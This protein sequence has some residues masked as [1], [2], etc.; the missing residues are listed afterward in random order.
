MAKQ[1][2]QTVTFN[3][4][5][6]IPDVEVV[7]GQVHWGE[8]WIV[9]QNPQT[10]LRPVDKK[11]WNIDEIDDKF[12]LGNS[13]NSL[14]GC[15]LAWII[16]IKSFTGGPGERYYAS[17]IITQDGEKVKTIEDSGPLDKVHTFTGR[18]L[19]KVS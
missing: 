5:M 13:L 14:D 6:G 19:L 7:I 17:L 2:I 16:D 8:Y 10:K 11:G 12:P 4:E 9:V 15:I 1:P 18:V 3:K